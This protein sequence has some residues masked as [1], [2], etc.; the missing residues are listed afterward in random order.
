VSL[1]APGPAPRPRYGWGGLG[2]LVGLG[3]VV[4]MLVLIVVVSSL[5]VVTE[6]VV[7]IGSLLSILASFQIF[8]VWLVPV[9]IFN[10]VMRRAERRYVPTD[11]DARLASISAFIVYILHTPLAFLL[12]VLTSAKRWTW[13]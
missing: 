2:A 10:L 9:L 6:H 11:R 13:W 12:L 1:N 3:S 8:A 5:R 4:T 7:V